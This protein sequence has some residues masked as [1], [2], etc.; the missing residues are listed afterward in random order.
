M[1]LRLHVYLLFTLCLILRTSPLA[2]AEQIVGS[3]RIQFPVPAGRCEVSDGTPAGAFF[4]RK[5]RE[6]LAASGNTL[7]SIYA[8]CDQLER[9]AAG[10]SPG[11]IADYATYNTPNAA[12]NSVYPPGI[13]SQVCASYKTMKSK[14]VE[15]NWQDLGSEIERI[16][17]ALKVADPKFLGVLF[18]DSNACYI[19]I[20]A[21]L[22]VEAARR[23]S[24]QVGITAFVVINGKYIAYQIYAPFR[25]GPST[26]ELL[27]KHKANVA[28]F[29]LS[30]AK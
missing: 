29:M 10:A 14:D 23:E 4:N 26:T 28:E 30:N 27:K 21:R 24:V 25:D 18:E 8:D 12:V 5:M 1:S 19:G 17:P 15:T 13:I 6:S 7:I 11:G 3:T 2:A 22:L 16:V 20:L 9:F